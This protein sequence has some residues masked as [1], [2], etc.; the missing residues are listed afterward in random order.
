[1]K[2]SSTKS[3]K[4]SP[5]KGGKVT[6]YTITTTITILRGNYIVDPDPLVIPPGGQV[7]WIVDNEDSELHT[8]SI[9]FDKFTHKN[10]GNKKEHPFPKSGVLSVV[11]LPG[12]PVAVSAY[13]R[14]KLPKKLESYKYE[15]ESASVDGPTRC[16]DPDLDVVDPNPLH[17]KM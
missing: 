17:R 8:V 2:K 7:I 6:A 3:A 16:L 4:K 5:N 11:A 10:N 1:M 13:V 15:I 12:V 14:A 9:D